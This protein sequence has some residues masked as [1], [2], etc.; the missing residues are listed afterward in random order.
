[1]AEFL[2][3]FWRVEIA[4]SARD[5]MIVPAW[6]LVEYDARLNPAVEREMLD[7]LAVGRD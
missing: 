5:D 7:N 6:L 4:A 1:L 2:A 3:S